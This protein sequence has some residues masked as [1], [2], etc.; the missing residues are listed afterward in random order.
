[1]DRWAN[2][3]A[4]KFPVGTGDGPTEEI[5]IPGP[6]G[7]NPYTQ[8]IQGKISGRHA[9]IFSKKCWKYTIISVSL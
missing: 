7:G 1:V 8:V 4:E 2:N 3:R 5:T 9:I 6:M